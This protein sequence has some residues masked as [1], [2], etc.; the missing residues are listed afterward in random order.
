MLTSYSAARGTKVN[1][2]RRRHAKDGDA[3]EIIEISDL[4]LDQFPEAFKGVDGLIHAGSP[5]IG[6]AEPAQ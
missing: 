2:L 1:D 3:V 4:A 5:I 6:R